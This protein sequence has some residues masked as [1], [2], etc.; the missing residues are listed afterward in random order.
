[1]VADN[2]LLAVRNSSWKGWLVSIAILSK[3]KA[4]TSAC[5]GG[6]AGAGETEAARGAEQ[7]I[8]HRG[9]PQAEPVGAHA[10]RRGAIGEQVEQAFLDAVLHLAALAVEVLVEIPGVIC[11]DGE[12][13]GAEARIGLAAGPFRL[14]TTRRSRP[15]LSRVDRMKS[16]K[17][18]AGALLRS[19][20]ASVPASAPA[21]RPRSAPPPPPHRPP[22]RCS[23]G[24]AAPP[25]RWRPLQT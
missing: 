2:P 14:P 17:R 9:E 3:L 6:G 25:R 23:P 11:P 18:R 4:Q 20:S 5:G 21:T 7:H 24:A 22:R 16:A 12:R 10:V 8:S 1:M 15:R 13:G 19:L